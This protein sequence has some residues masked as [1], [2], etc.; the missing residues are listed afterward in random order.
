MLHSGMLHTVCVI[1]FSAHYRRR[2]ISSLSLVVKYPIIIN[3]RKTTIT[4]LHLSVSHMTFNTIW[5]FDFISMFCM[6]NS[7]FKINC[8]NVFY[9]VLATKSLVLEIFL[10]NMVQKDFYNRQ[11]EFFLIDS[12][13]LTKAV[14]GPRPT[15]LQRE[16]HSKE[17]LES[18]Y[19][20][21]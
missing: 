19:P 2:T 20:R 12:L 10:T 11:Y 6:Y 16:S 17:Q 9:E 15:M 1:Y 21:C 8:W 7:I 3:T 14:L 18:E 13:K 5:R 4:F